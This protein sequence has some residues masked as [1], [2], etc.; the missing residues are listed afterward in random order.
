MR[1]VALSYTTDDHLNLTRFSIKNKLFEITKEFKEFKF[2]QN[3]GIE[4]SKNDE[5]FKSNI[6]AD[7][8]LDSEKNRI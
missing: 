7:P 5:V 8:W 6:L 1:Q 2:Q 4:F 3:L